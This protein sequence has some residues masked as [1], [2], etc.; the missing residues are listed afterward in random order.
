[1]GKNILIFGLPNSGKTT[2]AKQLI[3]DKQVAY[4]NADEI[5]TIFND[6]DF[7]ESGR[8]RQAE[9]M[10]GLTAYAFGDCVVDFVCPFNEWRDDYNITIWINTINKGRFEDT[11]KIFE[12]PNKVDYEIT[13]YNYT[14]ILQKIRNE[15][16]D[17]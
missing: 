7:T 11:N 10:I 13:N 2:F 5:R 6:W 9:R 17:K 12:K 4:F 1:M 8:I 14:D 16:K 3:K 15:L